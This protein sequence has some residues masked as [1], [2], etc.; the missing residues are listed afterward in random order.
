[1]KQFEII[2]RFREFNTLEELG[3]DDRILLEQAIE[4]GKDA[5]APYS[6]YYVGAAVR[7]ANGSIVK[8]NNQ[9]NVAYPSGLC[10]ERV[11]LF[12]ASALYP[13]VPVTAIAIAGHAKHFLITDPVTPCGACRQ[14]IAEYEQ[15]YDHPVRL[16]MKG[17]KSKIWIAESIT[18]LLPMMFRADELRKK[19]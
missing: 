10:A 3:E 12:A 16:V 2:N 15:L 7:L 1:M 14:V 9:E 6:Q 17:E 18:H 5:Y 11:A 8:G 19:R 4:S 13:G